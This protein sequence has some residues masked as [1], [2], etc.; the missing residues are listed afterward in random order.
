MAVHY[1]TVGV[2]QE[3][4]THQRSHICYTHRTLS[5]RCME[6]RRALCIAQA[7]VHRA[8]SI[9]WSSEGIQPVKTGS[10][11]NI[12]KVAARSTSMKVSTRGVSD[13]IRI[14][15]IGR[16]Q[17]ILKACPSS[18]FYRVEATLIDLVLVDP[19]FKLK[20]KLGLRQAATILVI[21]LSMC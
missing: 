21:I 11:H 19:E 13:T 14:T 2:C 15:I 12:A 16:F 17:P 18:H 6:H 20:S 7:S 4:R 1:Q 9:K 8:P 10:T 3:V 5:C